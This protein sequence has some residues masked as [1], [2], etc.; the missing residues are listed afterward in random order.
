MLG[1]H[2]PLLL[3]ISVTHFFGFVLCWLV[4]TERFAVFFAPVFFA[5][6]AILLS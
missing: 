1:W 2:R 5:F 3:T 6:F 4:G